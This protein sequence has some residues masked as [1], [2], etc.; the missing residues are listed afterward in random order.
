[1]GD[2]V[3]SQ[4]W[5]NWRAAFKL[6]ICRLSLEADEIPADQ[7][8]LEKELLGLFETSETCADL[9]NCDQRLARALHDG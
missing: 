7:H 9:R 6:V 1:M 8:R 3:T 5:T 2:K 4:L